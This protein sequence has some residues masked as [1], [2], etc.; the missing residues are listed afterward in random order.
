M[1][2]AKNCRGLFAMTILAGVAPLAHAQSGS[3]MIAIE[4]MEVGAEPAEFEL[5]RTG[6]GGPGRWT[7][8]LDTT[9]SGGRAI[10]QSSTE[11]TDTASRSRSTKAF[12]PRTSKYHFASNQSLCA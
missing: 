3:I 12:Q 1:R 2:I 4:K 6:R 10:E 7:V 9:A 8:I 5:A 11:R